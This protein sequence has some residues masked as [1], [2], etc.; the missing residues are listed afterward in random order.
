MIGKRYETFV[1]MVAVAVMAE[2]ATVEPITAVVMIIDM[3]S[4][5]KAALIGMRFCFERR[6]KYLDP[7]RIPSR[8][9][10]YVTRWADMKQLAVA[11]VESTQS[12][13]RIATAPFGPT[14]CTRYSAQLLAYVPLMIP[15]KSCMQKRIIINCKN[16]E[17]AGSN[18]EII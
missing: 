3:A 2:K 8:E 1:A 13:E 9:I 11:H 15:S 5:R 18:Q 14:S 4:T 16:V 10:A 6:R 12:R 17:S 7:G